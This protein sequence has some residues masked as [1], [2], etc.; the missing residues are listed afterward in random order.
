MITPSFVLDAVRQKNPLVLQITN[1]VS[2]NDCA[3]ISLCFGA[4]P[5]MSE[6]ADDARE[7]A[8]GADALL[9]NIGTVTRNQRKIMMAAIE[10]A[11]DN[12][13][14]VVLDPV[15]A[16]STAFRRDT[17]QMIM[18][19]G[20]LSVIKGNASEIKALA[21][22]PSLAHGVD[23]H[24]TAY[25]DFLLSLSEKTGAAIAVTGSIDMV[26]DGRYFAKITNGVEEMGTISGTGCM[27]GSC[28]A[29]AVSCSPA[30]DAVVSVFAILGIAGEQAIRVSSGPGTFKPAFFDAIVRM[31]EDEYL[32]QARIEVK[33]V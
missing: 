28:I 32:K 15:G 14:P 9:I 6:N 4:S 2:I 12:S 29:A 3:N 18:D 11:A 27:A 23:S 26:T 13:V 20:Y 17:A 31:T 25:P 33:N 1:T 7:L 5:V 10:S 22:L 16:G 30:F 19:T 8:V 24:E 21:G